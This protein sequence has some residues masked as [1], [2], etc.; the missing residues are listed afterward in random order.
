MEQQLTKK[1]KQK[2]TI[3]YKNMKL[4]IVVIIIII[5]VVVFAVVVVVVDYTARWLQVKCGK[6]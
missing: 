3:Q 2:R 1:E 6:E 5:I 4:V